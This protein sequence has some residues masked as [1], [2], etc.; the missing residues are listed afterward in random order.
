MHGRCRGILSRTRLTKRISGEGKAVLEAFGQRV[1][2]SRV[3]KRQHEDHEKIPYS[4]ERTGIGH[5]RVG[6]NWTAT[7]STRMVRLPVSGMDAE[8]FVTGKK[9][10]ARSYSEVDAYVCSRSRFQSN[11]SVS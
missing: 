10:Q 4:M 11:C 8:G 9:F 5:G 1:T 2:Y 7:L 6:M 3:Y